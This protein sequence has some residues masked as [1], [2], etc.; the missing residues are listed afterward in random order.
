MQR[1]REQGITFGILSITLIAMAI[2]LV[3]ALIKI[4]LSNRI[5]HESRQTHLIEQEVAA[6]REENTILHMRVEKLQYKSQ[7]A[8][9]IFSLDET[10]PQDGD[11]SDNPA[12]KEPQ[13]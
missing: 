6:L 7:I 11:A 9:T 3:L 13:P 8:D 5:Y 2:V 1:H 4:Y 12:Q 10:L